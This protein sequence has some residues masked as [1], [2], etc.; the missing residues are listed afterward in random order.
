M[1]RRGGADFTI[2]GGM[3]KEFTVLAIIDLDRGGKSVTNDIENVVQSLTSAGFLFPGKSLIY[4]DSMGN[5]DQVLHNGFGTFLS[6]ASIEPEDLQGLLVGCG[7]PQDAIN[8][9]A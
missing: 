6:F 9:D 4:R 3:A 1:R 7:V 2:V 8:R 5:W